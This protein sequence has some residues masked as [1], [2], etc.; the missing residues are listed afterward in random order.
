MMMSKKMILQS[1]SHIPKNLKKIKKEKNTKTQRRP[2]CMIF[3]SGTIKMAVE[4]QISEWAFDFAL[5]SI[6]IL[7][8]N[9]SYLILN[10]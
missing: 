7:N 8:I 4:I 5:L 3:I 2:V 9:K 6:C 10:F 1:K